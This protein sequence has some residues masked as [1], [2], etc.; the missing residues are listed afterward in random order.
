MDGS[1]ALPDAKA[2]RGRCRDEF[3]R[4]R[5][6]LEAGHENLRYQRFNEGAFGLK[7]SVFWPL[8]KVE[9]ALGAPTP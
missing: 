1:D 5:L 2:G 4:P 6:P 7:R 8:S 3:E 9:A